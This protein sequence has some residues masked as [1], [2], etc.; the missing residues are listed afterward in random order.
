MTSEE[1]QVIDSMSQE[2]MARIYRHSPS[3]HKYFIGG[4][5]LSDHFMLK[6]KESG[7]MTP[8]ISKKIGWD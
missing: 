4:S 5:E 8:E 3:G 2:Q 7:G 6:F 1:K